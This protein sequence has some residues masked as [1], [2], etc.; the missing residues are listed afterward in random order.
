MMF[1]ELGGGRGGRGKQQ[2]TVSVS[3]KKRNPNQQK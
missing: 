3:A 1:K 2:L